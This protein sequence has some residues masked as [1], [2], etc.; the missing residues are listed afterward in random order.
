M[1]TKNK[2]VTLK[3]AFDLILKLAK[4]NL[5]AVNIFSIWC[6]NEADIIYI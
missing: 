5:L 4:G 1:D 3:I 6:S 2:V